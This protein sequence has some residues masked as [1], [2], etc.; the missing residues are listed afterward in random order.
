[1]MSTIRVALAEAA[2]G[3]ACSDCRPEADRAQRPAQLV[4][5]DRDQPLPV[6][7]RVDQLLVFRALRMA[8]ASRSPSS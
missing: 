2:P 1:M 5:G 8:I 4:R 7:Q 6:A 3:C